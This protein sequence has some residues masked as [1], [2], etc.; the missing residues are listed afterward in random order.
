MALR[1]GKTGSR[2][3]KN[4]ELV[5]PRGIV[6]GVLTL[7]DGRLEICNPDDATLAWMID[8]APALGGRVGDNLLRTYKS[9]GETF[10]H[11]DDEA[12]RRRFYAQIQAAAKIDQTPNKARRRWLAPLFI[13]M[14]VAIA[15]VAS[16]LKTF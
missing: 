16:W 8:I 11:P 4:L 14:V 5:D 9:V 15:L 12:A 6:P 2:T 7:I 3:H 13:G 1:Q 10:E